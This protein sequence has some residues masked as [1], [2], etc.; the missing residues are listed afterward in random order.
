MK[1]TLI[2]ILAL[3]AVTGCSQLT[4]P[5]K[6][7]YD[8][9]VCESHFYFDEALKVNRVTHETCS[10]TKVASNREFPNGIV[11][12]GNRTTGAFKV[13]TATVKNASESSITQ[14]LAA[15]LVQPDLLQV[16]INLTKDKKDEL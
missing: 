5:S 2:L 3:A 4:G 10:Y 8:T 16:L 1:K 11:I 13:D 7:N 12:E 6:A 9:K 14:A 15:L